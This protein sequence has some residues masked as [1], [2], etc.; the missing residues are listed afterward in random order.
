M[1]RNMTD[2]QH[3][4]AGHSS[5]GW[6]T[7]QADDLPNGSVMVMC[8]KDPKHAACQGATAYPTHLVCSGGGSC[9]EIAKGYKSASEIQTLMTKNA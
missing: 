1:E 8:D 5:C 4:V 2:K 7:K 6:T 9:A 3:V